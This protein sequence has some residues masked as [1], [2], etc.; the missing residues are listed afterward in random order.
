[1]KHVEQK[2]KHC[3]KQYDSVSERSSKGKARERVRT[4]R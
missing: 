4:Q 1:M 2:L 3:S